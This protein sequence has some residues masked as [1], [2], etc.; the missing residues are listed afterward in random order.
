[1]HLRTSG[2]GALGLALTIRGTQM[3]A[4]VDSRRVGWLM[5]GLSLTLESWNIGFSLLAADCTFL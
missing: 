2:A 1:M 3:C 4:A 5:W